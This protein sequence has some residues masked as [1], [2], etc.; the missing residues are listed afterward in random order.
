[1]TDPSEVK[2]SD[3]EIDE[4]YALRVTIENQ[5]PAPGQIEATRQEGGEG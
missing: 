1:M 4:F 2:I 5:M 3:A